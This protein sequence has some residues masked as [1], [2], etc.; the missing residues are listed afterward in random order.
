MLRALIELL[1]TVF[2]I[3]VGRAVLTSV[4]KNVAKVSLGGFQNQSAQGER[5]AGQ[6]RT[7]QPSGPQIAG[8]LHKDPVCG[9]YVAES[10]AVRR[11]VGGRTIFYCSENCRKK[12][13]A[14]R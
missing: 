8:E 4:L 11:Q 5:A 14:A 2:I 6:R 10:S 12:D 3:V 13:A 1:F 7:E 9:T